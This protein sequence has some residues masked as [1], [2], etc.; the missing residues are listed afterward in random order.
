MEF[1]CTYKSWHRVTSIKITLKNITI[2]NN[3]KK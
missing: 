1:T 2:K 3:Y